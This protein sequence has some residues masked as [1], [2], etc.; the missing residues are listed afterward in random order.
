MPKSKSFK[1][2][3]I[4]QGTKHFYQCINCDKIYNHKLG[5]NLHKKFCPFASEI[6]VS[7][8]ESFQCARCV[9]VFN[10]RIQ[11]KEHILKKHNGDWR[12]AIHR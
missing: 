11:M 7:E 1:Q 2:K 8:K 6:V 3:T 9:L 12:E 4:F 5:L 10:N